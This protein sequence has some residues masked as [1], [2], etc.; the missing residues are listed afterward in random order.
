M[1]ENNPRSSVRSTLA[2]YSGIFVMCVPFMLAAFYPRVPIV[3]SLIVGAILGTPLVV[4][5][6]WLHPNSSSDNRSARRFWPTQ[7]ELWG[8]LGFLTFLGSF[9]IPLGILGVAAFLLPRGDDWGTVFI[10]IA[11]VIVAVL[12]CYWWVKFALKK[13]PQLFRG[14]IS[15]DTLDAFTWEEPRHEPKTVTSA[16]LKNWQ[17]PLIALIAFFVAFGVI[18]LSS[19]WLDMDGNGRRVRNLMRLIV[20]CRGNPNTVLSSSVL[21]G[22]GAL[23]LYIYRIR[24]ATT[25]NKL[26][27]KTDGM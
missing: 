27:T 2:T 15:D 23:G 10:R 11:F 12:G 13:L 26:Q 22:L 9:L 18:D 25:Q 7:T 8:I 1:P 16:V 19:P 14:K 24:R 6:L 5:G 21:L 4:L 3:I 20:W 17:L